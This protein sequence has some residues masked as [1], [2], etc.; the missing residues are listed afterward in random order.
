MVCWSL[1]DRNKD[2]TRIDVIQAAK[3]W[4]V[5]LFLVTG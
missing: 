5:M 4:L 1:N 2:V 3:V